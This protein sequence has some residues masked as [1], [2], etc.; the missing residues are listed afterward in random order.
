VLDRRRQ[1]A[2]LPLGDE[3][4]ERLLVG[5]PDDRRREC[6][7]LVRRDGTPVPGDEGG[8]VEVLAELALT[9][10]LGV[11]LRALGLSGTVDALDKLVA[12]YRSRLGRIVPEGTA[13]RRYP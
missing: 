11:A 5:V 6:W 2:L 4:A 13:P 1:L 9:R 8:G 10:P 12:R 7:W 3:N